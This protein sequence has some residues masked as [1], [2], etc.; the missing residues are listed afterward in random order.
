MRA[1][2]R[3]AAGL[4]EMLVEGANRL[5]CPVCGAVAVRMTVNVSM[6][7]DVLPFVR[8]DGE[9]D[10]RPLG[11]PQDVLAGAWDPDSYRAVCESCRTEWSV[12]PLPPVLHMTLYRG[13]EF[14]VWLEKRRRV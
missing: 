7:V 14:G 1:V 3:E 5:K 9:V 11:A 12:D 4:G 10:F 6:D 13:D 8:P 2:E